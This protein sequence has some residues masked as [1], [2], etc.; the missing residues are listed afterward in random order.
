VGPLVL[1]DPAGPPPTLVPGAGPLLVVSPGT[2]FA[3]SAEFF[4][5][6]VSEFAGSRWTVVV[7]TTHLPAEALGRLPRN[8]LAQRWIR[9]ADLV[10]R[11]D[12]LVTHGGMSSVQEAIL[13]GTPMVTAPR[14]REQR[15][16]ASRLHELGVAEAI[17]QGELLRQVERIVSN[18]LLRSRLDGIRARAARADGARRAADVVAGIADRRSPASGSARV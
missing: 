17:R 8:V 11:A 7:A 10:Q 2:V 14:S 16:T 13:A 3:R 18:P 9:Q 4:R 1:D 6:I 15:R 5:G 12:V